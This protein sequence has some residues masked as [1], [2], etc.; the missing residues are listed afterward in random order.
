MV[1]HDTVQHKGKEGRK[2]GGNEGR[3]KGG[4]EGRKEGH[5]SIR[6]RNEEQKTSKRVDRSL[7][8]NE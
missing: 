6:G 8:N 1:E 5:K 7:T 2:K 3:K 4:K